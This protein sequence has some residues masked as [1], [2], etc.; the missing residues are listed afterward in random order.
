MLFQ[1]AAA[2][3]KI[4]GSIKEVTLLKQPDH[5]SVYFRMNGYVVFIEPKVVLA[6]ILNLQ[7]QNK[8]VSN[9]YTLNLD[10]MYKQLISSIPLKENFD[11][12]KFNFPDPYYF[13]QLV[14]MANYAME[15]GNAAIISE[16]QGIPV[17]KIFIKVNYNSGVIA[18]EIHVDEADGN[19]I[20]G[21]L[22]CISN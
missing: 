10:K 16:S 20:S 19:Y 17:N 5:F 2:C 18:K 9:F 8:G 6:D 21:D 12:Y 7:K 13:D 4:E 22:L 1:T 3:E 14:R 15:T 11:L